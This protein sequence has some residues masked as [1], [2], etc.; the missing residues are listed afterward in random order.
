MSFCFILCDGHQA[1]QAKVSPKSSP[2]PLGSGCDT[3]GLHGGWTSERDCRREP[4]RLYQ[5]VF[6]ERRRKTSQVDSPTGE[7]ST[8]GE[9]GFL[10]QKLQ[11]SI[12][13]TAMDVLRGRASSK[14]NHD[15]AS[16]I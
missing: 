7:K 10:D 14:G 3:N 8:K 1:S 4:V 6:L 2:N 16:G 15:T 13:W 5:E 11:K 12:L 9:G